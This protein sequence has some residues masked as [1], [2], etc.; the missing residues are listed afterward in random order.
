VEKQA[1]TG[2]VPMSMFLE[3]VV[4]LALVGVLIYMRKK[5]SS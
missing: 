3:I 2:E 4:V 1:A 5:R